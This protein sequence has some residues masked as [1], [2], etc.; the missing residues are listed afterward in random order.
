MKRLFIALILVIMVA[1][2][3]VSVLKWLGL[4]PFALEEGAVAEKKPAKPSDEPPRFIDFAPLLIPVIGDNKV[5]VTINIQLKLE[6]VG[7]ENEADLKRMLPR[8][9]DAFVR[10]LHGFIPRLLRKKERLDVSIIKKRMELI[11][12]RVAGKDKITG[13]LIQSITNN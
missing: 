10:D 8:L 5:A 12:G 7:A 13:V 1:G 9:N 4:G 6:T 2:G 11:G 3:T